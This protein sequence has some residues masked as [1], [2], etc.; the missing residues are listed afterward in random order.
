M[1]WAVTLMLGVAGSAVAGDGALRGRFYWGHE[2]ESF[3]PC[4][5]KKAYW[6]KG[7]KKVLQPLRERTERLR[8][9]RG[10]PYQ[11]IYVEAV[12]AIDTKSRREG[13]AG[14]YHGLFHLRKV[15]RAS[16]VVPKDCGK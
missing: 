9:Q 10:K 4:G 11:P 16:N 5:S 14:D 8:E 6:V 1:R 15:A 12:G 7:D 13:F 3:Q 2:V